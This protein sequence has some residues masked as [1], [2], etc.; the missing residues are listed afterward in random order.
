[1]RCAKLRFAAR[2]GAAV[3]LLAALGGCEGVRDQL[4]LTKQA[5]DEFSVVT[6]APLVLPPDFSLRPPQPG[7][8]GPQENSPRA[9][10]REALIGGGKNG[11]RAAQSGPSKGERALLRMAGAAQTRPDIR[12]VIDRET[13][14]LIADSATFAD[15]LM[16]W[17]SQPPPGTV[18]DAEKEA[19]RLRENL[20]A[21]KPV[22]EG[23]TPTIKRRK[24]APLEGI[25]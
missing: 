1:M 5:P 14:Q 10:A 12:E 8:T 2:F 15:R 18:V 11:E 16:F 20:A 17:Q 22:T 6:K 19:Q 21:G 25:F 9:A 24:R 4:G 7:A 3:V 13:A 23:E